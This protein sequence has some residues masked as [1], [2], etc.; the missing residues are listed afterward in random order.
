MIF[1]FLLFPLLSFSGIIKYDV[2]TTDKA[3]FSFQT[4]CNRMFRHDSP[5]IDVVSGAELD[6]M[7]RKL[8][9]A[10]F[11]DKE[12]AHDPYLL[13]GEVDAEAKKVHCYSG[14][15]VI[16]KYQCVKL[17]DREICANAENSCK[18]MQKKLAR[19]LD[20]VH[21]SVTRSEKGIKE[22]NCYYE[23]LPSTEKKNGTL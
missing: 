23:S 10:D 7:S 22:L 6:C 8:L 14:T 11:C 12:L 21:S 2:S 4:A 13:R 9:V 15:K 19:R 16:L 18:D 17:S 5:M 3:S 1:A 20:I